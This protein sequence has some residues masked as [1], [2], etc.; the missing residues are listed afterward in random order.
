MAKMLIMRTSYR[1]QRDFV[2]RKGG[3]SN[4][5]VAKS[6]LCLHRSRDPLPLPK[7]VLSMFSDEE[8]TVNEKE[9]NKD[10]HMGRTRAFAHV[11]GNWATYLYIP[12]KYTRHSTSHITKGL[13]I[14]SRNTKHLESGLLPV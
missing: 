7:D 11:A 9:D 2:M 5:L 8:E 4:N 1:V 13:T 14:C 3:L 12:C 10:L 6:P